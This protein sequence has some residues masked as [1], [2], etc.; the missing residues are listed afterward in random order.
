MWVVD[1]SVAV[2]WFLDEAGDREA[3]ALVETRVPLLA[4]ELVVAE[5]SNV[6]WKRLLAGDIGAKQATVICANVPKVFTRLFA[7]TDLA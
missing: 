7:L 1:A 3:R 2:K 6:A 4:P 5:V